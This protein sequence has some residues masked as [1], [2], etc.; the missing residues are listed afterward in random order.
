MNKSQKKVNAVK[1]RAEKNRIEEYKEHL[2]N[3]YMIN[4]S[5]GILGIIL[6]VFY[7]SLYKSS[8][9]LYMNTVSWVLTA[10]FAVAGT[11][12]FVLGK[13][14]VIKN[15]SRACNYGIFMWVCAAVALW[16]ALFNKLRM[17]IESAAR[18]I[19]GNE[20]LAVTSYWN[21]RLPIIAIVV[22]LVIAFI[23]YLV[24]LGRK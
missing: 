4:L 7:G 21:Y 12:L 15:Q 14:G 10:L 22:Y 17:V 11:A 23:I 8:V 16:F 3:W 24:K 13:T 18:A 9:L 6:L 20:A 1:R 19:T 5:W 2:T